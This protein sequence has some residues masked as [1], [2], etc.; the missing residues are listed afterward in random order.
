MLLP[1]LGCT[2]IQSYL[3]EPGF[4]I[5]PPLAADIPAELTRNLQ[6]HFL[7]IA[8][9][10]G[11]QKGMNALHTS[12]FSPAI[13]RHVQARRRSG[14][15]P[16]GLPKIRSMVLAPAA[17]PLSSTSPRYRPEAPHAPESAATIQAVHV[18][19]LIA[20]GDTTIGYLSDVN[21]QDYPKIRI[22]GF[23]FL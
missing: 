15:H 2:Y 18:S 10:A 4:R 12:V 14:Q 19:G 9:V 11:R 16:Q 3:P 6:H 7:T 5:Q 17:L 20:Y 21:I 1:L 23:R 8:M 13:V 22:L